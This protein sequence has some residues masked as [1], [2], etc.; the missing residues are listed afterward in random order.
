MPMLF[1]G[2]LHQPCDYITNVIKPHTWLMAWA[3]CHSLPA[4]NTRQVWPQIIY[5]KL[6]L[7]EN[8]CI[9]SMPNCSTLKI[10]AQIETVA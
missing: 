1:K 4:S 10:I 7:T 3:W 6:C 5:A 2:K 9:F 8:Y